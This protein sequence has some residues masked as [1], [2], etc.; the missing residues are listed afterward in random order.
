[1]SNRHYELRKWLII[2][3]RSVLKAKPIYENIKDWDMQDIELYQSLFD[4][5]HNSTIEKM[6]FVKGV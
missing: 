6:N 5:N 1:M 3:T 2:K 4:G